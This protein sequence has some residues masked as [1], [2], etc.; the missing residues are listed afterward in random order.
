MSARLSH[1]KIYVITLHHLATPDKLTF[2]HQISENYSS[3]LAGKNNWNYENMINLLRS[4]YLI[5]HPQKSSFF[6]EK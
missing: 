1:L 2:R 4:L 5:S 3:F 6:Y